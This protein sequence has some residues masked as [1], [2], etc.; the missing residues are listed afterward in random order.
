MPHLAHLSTD[1]KLGKLILLQEKFM[2]QKKN[3]IYLHLCFSIMSQQLSTKVADV[4]HKRFLAL[5][6]G[7]IPSAK[8]IRF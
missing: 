7:R 3:N 2:L 8:Q 6:K 5:Y 1:K 4:F